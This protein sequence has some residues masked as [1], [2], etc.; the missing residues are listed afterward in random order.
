[1]SETRLMMVTM[2]DG[3]IWSVPVAVIVR[4]QFDFY[5]GMGKADR[6]DEAPDDYEI[7]DWAANSMDWEDVQRVATK[8]T[9]RPSM[10]TASDFQDGWV[11][12]EKRIVD[13]P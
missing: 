5:R 11:N 9:E 10:M 7:H 12:G 3:S 6:A 2:P 1:M 8:A 4:N 13:A